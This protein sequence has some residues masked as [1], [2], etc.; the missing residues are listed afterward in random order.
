ME[1]PNS[2]IVESSGQYKWINPSGH[3]SWLF[4][5]MTIYLLDLPEVPINAQHIG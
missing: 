4:F 1:Y 5:T 2:D 3:L